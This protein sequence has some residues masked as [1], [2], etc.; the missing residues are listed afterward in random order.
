MPPPRRRAAIVD[1]ERLARAEMRRLLAAHPGIEIVTEAGSV[2]EAESVLTAARPD[3]LF[4]DIR[5]PDGTG[6]DL[7]DRLETVPR[8]I[9][10]TAHDEFALRAFKVN[11]LDYLLKPVEPKRLAEALARLSDRPTRPDPVSPAATVLTAADRV[12]LRDGDECWFVRLGEVR[13]FEA[14]GRGTLLHLAERSVRTHRT[15]GQLEARLDPATF[16]RANRQQI[17]TLRWIDTVD[18]WFNGQLRARL[19][20]GTKIT[21]SRRRARAFR[22]LMSL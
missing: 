11:A 12:F 22:E 9:F 2:A 13:V 1:D 18:E 21:L 7:L 19:T 16:F 10:T 17:V 8:V 6:F 4:L 14:D 15:L 5:M 3:L 20:D